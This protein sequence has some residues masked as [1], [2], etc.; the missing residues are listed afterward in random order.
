MSQ[1]RLSHITYAFQAKGKR[2]KAKGKRQKAKGNNKEGF[3]GTVVV[4][5]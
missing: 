5:M 1:Q 4:K 3:K 2:Q